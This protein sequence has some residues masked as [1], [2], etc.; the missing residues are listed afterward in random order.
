MSFSAADLV[1]TIQLGGVATANRD[2]DRF[3]EKL[4]NADAVASKL[5]K[6]AEAVFRGAA[7]T[8]GVA[9]VAA[10]AYVSSLFK[11]GVAYNQLQQ[12]SRAALKTLVGGTEQANAQMDKLD[13]FAKTSPFSKAVFI[14]AQQQLIGFGMEAKKVI[15]T[16]DAMQDAVAATGGSSQQLGDLVFILAQI[17]AAGKITGQDLLQ[18]GQRGV[19]AAELIG[20]QM[21]LTGAQIKKEISE[22]TL[23]AGKAIDA[24][25]AGMKQ[26][27]GGAAANVKGTFS[28]TVDRIQAA[29]RDIGAALAEPF[30]SKN[31]G[32]LAVT[33]GN[34]VAD[35]MRAVEAHVG[36]VVSIL[37]RKATPAFNDFTLLLDKARVQVKSWDPSRL[38][39]GFESMASNAPGLAALAGAVLGVN[40]QLLASIPIVGRFVPAF[41]PLPGAIAAAALASPELRTELGALLGELRPLVPVTVSLATTMSG[42]LNAALPVV[43]S[44]I[45]LVASVAGPLVDMISDI[46]SPML[47]T[48]AAAVAVYVAMRSASPALQGFVDNV[49]RIGEQA[50][51]QAAL[52]GMEGNTGRFAGTLGVA[53]KAATG[54]SNS[55]KAAFISNPVGLIILGVST[56]A[57]ILTAALGDQAEKAKETKERIQGYRDVL[58]ETTGALTGLS[59]AQVE[60]NLE[61]TKA[62]QYAKELKLAYR[63][64]V[65][66]SLGN[67]DAYK[68]VTAAQTKYNNSSYEA[69]KRNET[70]S[71]STVRLTEEVDKQKSAIQAAAD[72]NR[73]AAREAR[74]LAA[75]MTEADRSNGRLNEAL[76]IARD[77]SR[78]ATERLRALKQALDELNGGTKTQAELTR[79]LNEQA[80]NLTE[81]FAQTD[82]KGNKLATSLVNASGQIDTTSRAGINLHD[83]VSRLN[84]EM[85]NAITLADKEAKARG[86]SGLAMDEASKKAQPYIDKLRQIAKDAGLSDEQVNGLVQNMLATPS[87]VAFLLT[88]NGTIDVQKQ[89]LLTLAQQVLATPDGSFVVEDGASIAGIEKQLAS[90][91]FK[92]EHLPNGK[93]RVTA[94]GVSSVE[95]AL[96]NLARTRTMTVRVTTSGSVKYGNKEIT[97]GMATG[98]PVHGPGTGTSDTA[99]LFRLSNGEHVATAREVQAA[100]GHEGMF[101]IRQALLNGGIAGL[102]ALFPGRASGGPI[103]PIRSV[104]ESMLQVA[105]SASSAPVGLGAAG[106]EALIA[107]IRSLRAELGRPNVSITENFPVHTDPAADRLRESV[108]KE[109]G[110]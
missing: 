37:T 54:L 30:V 15:P 27:F 38:E 80:L 20:S 101:R 110:L 8:I 19:N 39:R 13:A 57:A 62:R 76:S 91:G 102:A 105:P 87:V 83:Q 93:V 81:A 79:D 14:T 50:A 53:G 34:Q 92:I 86:D 41:G 60:K 11:T 2:L 43:A 77:V 45:R 42:M 100:G 78:D 97:P 71:V 51:V 103:Y 104:G 52:A 36:P 23:D 63:D 47:A 32:G 17:Q 66:A 72:E 67:E 49:R 3:H 108:V 106:L 6:N 48:A 90:M 74:E 65:D 18:F 25:T 59:R 61:D 69:W 9:T 107:E 1:A 88:D 56:A 16:L 24:L 70:H 99:G 85:L 26:K 82:E 35:V 4:N 28:G 10:A 68:R 29:S 84:D 95:Q 75:S 12:T 21:G 31:G 109:A 94:E 96:N 64:V 22:G 46:P 58:D 73:R 33:W 98:G 40:S 5:G 55:L 7:T 89:Q 44:G